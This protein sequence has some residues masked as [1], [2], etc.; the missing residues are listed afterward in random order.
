M[1]DYYKYRKYKT[2]YKQLVLS[3]LG[4]EKTDYQIS[5]RE[6]W[7]SL[8]RNGDKTVEGRPNRGIFSRMKT[9][10][11][12]LFYN[13]DTRTRERRQFTVEITGKK[14]YKSFE[15]LIATEGIENILPKQGFKTVEQAVSV[16]RQWY[17][18]ET[19]R[20]GVLGIHVKVVSEND[21]SEEK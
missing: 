2:K 19:E 11:T 16:Y 14:M 7:F 13:F 5:V 20:D 3:L 18:K 15:E 12:I 9:G 21:S 10:Q 6:P 4:G 17:P 1:S 8:I